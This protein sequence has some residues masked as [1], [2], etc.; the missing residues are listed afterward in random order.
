MWNIDCFIMI[1]KRP[2]V[3]DRD[4]VFLLLTQSNTSSSNQDSKERQPDTGHGPT[5]INHIKYFRH[6]WDTWLSE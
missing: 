4:V 5:K 1:G 2:P 6:G 3:I